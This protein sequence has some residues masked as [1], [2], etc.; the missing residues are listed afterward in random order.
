[1]WRD[2][3][4]ALHDAT[5]ARV[6]AYSRRGF[7]RSEPR[8]SPYDPRFMHEEALETL[9]VLRRKLG[10]QNPVLLGHSTGASMALIHAGANRWPVAAVVAMAPIT[11]IEPSNLASIE[12][13]RELWRTTD[14]RAKLARHHDDVDMAWSAWNDTWL[15]PRFREW[16]IEED[17]R[18]LRVPILAILGKD[19][20]YSTPAQ[21]EYV[22]RL[23]TGVPSFELV[24]LEDCGHAPHRDH[25][26]A[27]VA[28]VGKL[29]A[30]L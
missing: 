19:D 4:R 14:W 21:V 24:L 1:M 30:A 22:R 9:P 12:R 3:P 7:G 28:A 27:V 2:F 13:A 11:F 5:G 8:T 15:D 23:A 26:G 20:E 29:L 25:P 6:I 17:V 18:A 10:I 16:T